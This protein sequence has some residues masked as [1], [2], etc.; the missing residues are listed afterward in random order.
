MAVFDLFSKRKRRDERA[1]QEDIF[2]YEEL[3][4]QFRAQVVHISRD[5]LGH[6][7]TPNPFYRDEH[8]PNAHWKLIFDV[9]T[10]EKGVFRLTNE[11]GDP[12]Y[13]CANYVLNAQTE[14]ALDIIQVLFCCIDRFARGMPAQS[15]RK[16]KLTDPDE[17]IKE[18]NVRFREHGIGYKY[19]N[20][21]IMRVDSEYLHAQAVKPALELLRGAGEAFAGPMEEFLSAH[22]HYRHGK[23]KDAI[24]N[25]L[26]AFESTMKAVCTAR[27]WPFDP[28]KDTA[29]K[30]IE[31]VLDNELIPGYLQTHFNALRSVLEAGLPTVSNRTSRHGQGSQPTTVPDHLAAYTLHLTAA[32][33]VLLLEAHKATA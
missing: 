20:G 1:G 25:A 33:V 16:Y 15:R 6:Y 9:V 7:E 17:A 30:L 24:A 4:S 10:R 2:Q 19:E 28:Q 11:A 27:R 26:K 29:S 3:P 32:N 23:H 12:F 22:D 18:L 13:Q 5:A 21:H 31:I 14:D 8:L